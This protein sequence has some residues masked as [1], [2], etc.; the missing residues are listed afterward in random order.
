M[1]E[2]KQDI[3]RKQPQRMA[4]IGKLLS[5]AAASMQRAGVSVQ[6]KYREY[7]T[8]KQ[9]E[10]E[11]QEERRIEQERLY[12]E[13]REKQKR[14]DEEKAKVLRQERHQNLM[15]ALDDDFHTLAADMAP[16]FEAYSEQKIKKVM[17]DWLVSSPNKNATRFYQNQTMV[18][19][20]LRKEPYIE[21]RRLV[22]DMSQKEKGFL[23]LLSTLNV[24]SVSV[25]QDEIMQ[26]AMLA[27]CYNE[28]KSDLRLY[29]QTKH[30][31]GTIHMTM[32]IIDHWLSTQTVPPTQFINKILSLIGEFRDT[33]TDPEIRSLLETELQGAQGWM[34]ADAI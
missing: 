25:A 27:L 10:R 30:S 20:Q 32:L 26:A 17:N 15:R 16:V 21:V 8:Q 14:E 12:A 6:A 19:S 31:S 3:T 1:N 24:S 7:Q 29:K 28:G 33:I 23:R 13:A 18:L 5:K 9:I 2:S 11:R 34:R 4:K 22:G